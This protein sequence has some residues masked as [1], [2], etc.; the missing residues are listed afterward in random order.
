MSVFLGTGDDKGT[1]EADAYSVSSNQQ[2]D[3]GQ[4]R[5]QQETLR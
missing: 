1:G 2:S 4:L 3:S 5:A